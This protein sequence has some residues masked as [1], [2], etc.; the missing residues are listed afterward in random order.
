MKTKLIA[1]TVLALALAAGIAKAEDSAEQVGVKPATTV[2]ADVR[3]TDKYLTLTGFLPEARPSIQSGAY[4]SHT[5][6]W[7]TLQGS[8][9]ISAL[10]EGDGITEVDLGVSYHRDVGRQR[11]VHIAT[12]WNA[13]Y[14]PD[15]DLCLQE[16]WG[17][18]G[19]NNALKPSLTLH[20]D[21]S[22]DGNGQYAELAMQ[23]SIGI[24]DRKLDLT[25]ALIYNSEYFVEGAGI[26]GIRA[27]LQY[28]LREGKRWALD[29]DVRGF[30]ALNG[31]QDNNYNVGLT[32]RL[33]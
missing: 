32:L 19:M 28:P 33:K 5:A 25:A 1:G 31:Q 20:H 17:S 11:N 22:R 7:G 21:Y 9:W 10:L 27:K 12:G 14:L 15:P 26:S 2:T 13:Y 3:I 18:I 6:T 4:L 30:V 23:P 16:V 24:G 8:T 29:A